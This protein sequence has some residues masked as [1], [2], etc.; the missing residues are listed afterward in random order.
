MK[1]GPLICLS[2]CWFFSAC[3]MPG[4]WEPR[5][6]L[7]QTSECGQRGHELPREKAEKLRALYDTRVQGT[8]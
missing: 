4:A 2:N 1:A 3:L 8:A 5:N 7:Y 6:K